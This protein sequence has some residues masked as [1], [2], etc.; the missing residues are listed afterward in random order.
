[1]LPIDDHSYISWLI[2]IGIS[3]IIV[4]IVGAFLWRKQKL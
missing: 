2:V 3:L 1:P 4:T